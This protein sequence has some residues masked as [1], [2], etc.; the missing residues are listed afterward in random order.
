M[1]QP[2]SRTLAA[3]LVLIAA[4]V[5][6]GSGCEADEV[7][8]NA[9]RIGF[10]DVF[11][12]ASAGDIGGPYVPAGLNLTVKD[13]QTLYVAYIR[14]LSPRWEVELAF[15]LPPTTRTYGKGPATVGS[16]P[17]DG[18]E[19]STA[20]WFAPTVLVNYKLLDETWPVR[21]YIGAGISYVYFYDRQSTTGGNAV[22]GGP[23]SLSL[24]SSTG[25]AATVGVGWQVARHCTINASYSFTQVRTELTANTDGIIRQTHVSFG[26]QALVVAV[27]YQF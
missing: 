12:H 23:T 6:P 8:S 21:P 4:C 20:K 16:V 26:P 9:L 7:A 10:Y 19:L 1:T 5:A 22:S 25:P 3:A 18:V 13:V 14:R 17:Y 2:Q 24:P 11:Y 27:G 15:G